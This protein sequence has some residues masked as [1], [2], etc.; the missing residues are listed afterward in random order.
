MQNKEEEQGGT[1]GN[2]RRE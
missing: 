2:R 1:E